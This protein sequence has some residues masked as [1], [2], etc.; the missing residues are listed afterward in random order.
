[1]SRSSPW[2]IRHLPKAIVLLFVALLFACG[3]SA[4]ATP[5]SSGSSSTPPTAAPEP[6]STSQPSAIGGVTPTPIPTAAVQATKAAPAKVKPTGTINYGV[7]E[8]GIFEAHPRFISSPRYQYVA[9]T[10]GES[11]V[12]INPDLSPGPFLAVEW[13]ISDDF[14]VWTWRIRDD[15]EFQKGYGLLTVEDILYSFKEYHDGALNAR[16]GIIGDFWVGNKGGSQTVIDDFT[17]VVDTGEPWIPARAFEFMRGLGGL[18]TSIVSKKQSEELT[19]EVASKDIAMTGP[20]EIESHSSGEFWK[21][22]AVE[23]HWRQTPF[24]EG[25]VLWTIPEESARLAGFQTGTLD[26]FQMAFDTLISVEEVP[27]ATVISWP[28]AGQAGLNIY[29]QT[30][31]VDKDG[32]PYEALDCS[33]AWVSCDED[34]DSVEW[35]NAVKVKKAMAISI[36][37]QTIVDTLLSGFGNVLYMRDWMG[38]EAKAD[39]RWV[40]K[41]DPELAKQLLVDAGYPDGFTITLTPAIRGAPAET[42][43]CEAVAQYWEDIGISVKI[44]NVPYATI[45]PSLITRQYQGVTCHTVGARLNPIIGASNYVKQSTFSYGTEHPWME[46]HISAALLEVDPA[47]IELKTREVYDFF[48]DN[49]MAFALYAFDGLWPIGPALDPD[50]TPYGFSEVRTP[51][52]F[53]YIKHR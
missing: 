1:M 42:E 5:A 43:A 15:V 11:M 51:S 44:Q 39:P 32:N 36:D 21:F 46:E 33:N 52:G 47:Q 4:T 34:L 9:V 25:L 28:N 26:T 31:G 53:E 22:T 45:R 10:A 41:Y 24:F 38:H 49:V 27:G 7:K 30:Y 29:G 40:H 48:Y 17:V 13:S 23:D 14:L 3:S 2:L 18:S 20:W 6:T 12:T 16:A 8:T 50:W 37:R 19:P 35:A